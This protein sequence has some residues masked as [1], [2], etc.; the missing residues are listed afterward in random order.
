M[1]AQYLSL[2]I[3][4]IFRPNALIAIQWQCCKNEVMK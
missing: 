4:L 1:A 2:G 3:L